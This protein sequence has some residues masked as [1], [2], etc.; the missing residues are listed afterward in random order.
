MSIIPGKGE[1]LLIIRGKNIEQ[2]PVLQTLVFHSARGII[3]GTYSVGAKSGVITDH[4]A[5]AIL[6]PDGTVYANNEQ[7]YPSLAAFEASL[8]G[9]IN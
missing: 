6:A 3:S 7:S 9:G 1:V 2:E 5:Y 4:D 8:K